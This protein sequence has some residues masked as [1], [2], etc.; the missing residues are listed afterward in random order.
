LAL[1]SL[2]AAHAI[3]YF[4]AVGSAASPTVRVLSISAAWS[5][6]PNR[7]AMAIGRGIAAERAEG[8]HFGMRDP[9]LMGNNGVLLINTHC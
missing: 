4:R 2:S 5:L 9:E 1:A 7:I 6:M 8:I 3:P